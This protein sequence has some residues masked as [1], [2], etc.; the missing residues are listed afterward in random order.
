MYGCVR[1]TFIFF[2]LFLSFQYL[3][4]VDSD[5]KMEQQSEN[6]STESETQNSNLTESETQQSQGESVSSQGESGSSN[7]RKRK[8][9]PSTFSTINPEHFI[10]LQYEMIK[11]YRYDS[12]MIYTI[13][14]KQLY[15]F[16]TSCALGKS[17]KCPVKKCGARVYLVEGGKC[18]R[19]ITGARHYHEEREAVYRE[20]KCLNEIKRRCLLLDQLVAGAKVSVKSIFETVLRE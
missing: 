3:T 9:T 15:A 18:I 7:K 5:G 14:E 11:G 16:N 6:M 10:E 4:L 2:F 17:Y 19:I 8:Q 13:E 12:N 1:W 20:L